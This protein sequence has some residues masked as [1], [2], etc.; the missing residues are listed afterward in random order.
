MAAIGAVVNSPLYKY[1]MSFLFLLIG[2]YLVGA[3]QTSHHFVGPKGLLV[4]VL[5]QLV[6]RYQVVILFK[7]VLSYIVNHPST[8]MW[9]SNYPK[10]LG[11]NGVVESTEEKWVEPDHLK[12]QCTAKT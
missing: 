7:V 3:H 9:E 6:N 11:G 10:R 4:L 2:R 1:F 5:H 12:D 8:N